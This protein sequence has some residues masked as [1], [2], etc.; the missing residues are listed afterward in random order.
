MFFSALSKILNNASMSID[1]QQAEGNQISLT[2]IPRKNSESNDTA[3]ADLRPIFLT[4]TPEELDSEF[5]KGA[6]GALGQLFIARKTLADQIREQTEI[7][8]AAAEAEKEAAEERKKSKASTTSTPKTPS[9]PKTQPTQSKRDA[10]LE[11]QK[12][13]P[14][15]ASVTPDDA[16]KLF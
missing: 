7:E 11:E 10:V 9:K 14:I 13:V 3:Q 4:G 15:P 12:N 8:K 16:D 2:L 6:D 1:L 5:A